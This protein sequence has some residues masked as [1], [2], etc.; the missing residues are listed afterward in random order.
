MV[1][2]VVSV[3]VEVVVSVSVLLVRTVEVDLW[4]PLSA[5]VV[6]AVA[7]MSFPNLEQCQCYPLKMGLWK[8][9]M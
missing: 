8:V 6:L 1:V 9:D 3:S 4:T 7:K 2:V 5:M